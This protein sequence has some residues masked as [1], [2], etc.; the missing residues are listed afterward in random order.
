MYC[1]NCGEKLD[2]DA[3]FCKSCGKPVDADPITQPKNKTAEKPVNRCVHCG[4]KLD[5]DD[6]FCTSCGKPV[7][8][9]ANARPNAGTASRTKA[10]NQMNTT[11]ENVRKIIAALKN[12]DITAMKSAGEMRCTLDATQNAF[13]KLLKKGILTL[14]ALLLF[15][16]ARADVFP[17]GD[18]FNGLNI[19]YS[20]S[21]GSVNDVEDSKG[22]TESRRIFGTCSKGKVTISG[23]VYSDWG[24]VVTIR[25]S[26]DNGEKSDEKTYEMKST[27]KSQNFSIS[28]PVS[29]SNKAVSFRVSVGA[30]Y[31]NG[32]SRGLALYGT[33]DNTGYK[34]AN[35]KD[36]AD[37]GGN[38]S[39][40]TS[41]D[42]ESGEFGWFVPTAI[43]GAIAAGGIAL[44]NRKKKKNAN[45]SN[46]TEDSGAEKNDDE[47]DDEEDASYLMCIWKDFGDTLT[48]GGEPQRVYARIV[49]STPRNPGTTDS[50]LTSKINITG[51]GY[52][53]VS[54]QE[55][56]GEYMSALVEAPRTDDVPKGAVVNFC[57]SGGGAS[58]TN[59]MHF[60]IENC[61]P[62][63]NFPDWQFGNFMYIQ[64]TDNPSNKE[65]VHFFFDKTNVEPEQINFIGGDDFTIEV[66][67][68]EHQHEYYAII[69]N[70]RGPSLKTDEVFGTKKDIRIVIEALFPGQ[71]QVLGEFYIMLYPE[72]LCVL[73]KPKNGCI[74][75]ISY[76]QPS[77]Y[78]ADPRPYFQGADIY[79]SYAELNND[80]TANIKTE[81]RLQFGKLDA[82]DEMSCNVAAKYR[83]KLSLYNEHYHIEPEDSI[84]EGNQACVVYLPAY[85]AG[86]SMEGG[87]DLS[88]PLRLRGEK[89]DPMG[90]WKKEHHD[91]IARINRYFPDDM[92]Q[93]Y[94]NKVRDMYSDPETISAAELRFMSYRVIKE[95]Q[96]YWLKQR[97]EYEICADWDDY[98]LDVLDTA[99]SWGD[100]CFSIVIS[101]YFGSVTD[102]WLSPTKDIA[103]NLFG[104]I[105]VK[106]RYG[107]EFNY[108]SL[109]LYKNTTQ[110]G[111]NLILDGLDI[112]GAANPANMKKAAGIMVSYLVY[113]CVRKYFEKPPKERDWYD[114]IRDGFSDLTSTALKK[115]AGKYLEDIIKGENKVCKKL[116][117]WFNKYA[118]ETVKKLF[119]NGEEYF[120]QKILKNSI[121]GAARLKGSKWIQPSICLY[122]VVEK[123]ADL[124]EKF[125]YMDLI[126][127]Y[128]NDKLCGDGG[129]MD[130]RFSIEDENCLFF[131]LDISFCDGWLGY[132]MKP[133]E[134]TLHLK[135]PFK[136]FYSDACEL[137]NTLYEMLFGML[138]PA[139]A[140][141]YFSQD[142]I[143]DL[144]RIEYKN[145]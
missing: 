93:T 109:E 134:K 90:D 98:I 132:P 22:F 125:G 115:V 41:A 42:E 24:P 144:N 61:D 136:A 18:G 102:A 91:L 49:K 55:I 110:I 35:G 54:D 27:D 52:L 126:L 97:D 84:P 89:E 68:G 138:V 9:G 15:L 79:I 34:A 37:S 32:E 92:A 51:D 1:I 65:K 86:H 104:E 72:G 73:N 56:V 31:G 130:S 124:Y 4:E 12:N 17:G 26:I 71:I 133:E 94:I 50:V 85:V 23:T 123:D 48:L 119:S 101:Y 25:V 39:I 2:D 75:V 105:I 60:M 62:V 114:A 47:E 127:N 66:E 106:F 122:D 120:K 77:K 74:E 6:R 11:A 58:F 30:A 145:N 7:V 19:S 128:L 96:Y 143:V 3:R 43:A 28:I 45:K 40:N 135:I 137:T 59:R 83:Y 16:P 112:S 57:L 63:I 46:Q 80:Y 29:K 87:P 142:P 33:L 21:G 111:E 140:K 82:K 53:H 5:D 113:N 139:S 81:P 117:E 44:K 10:P 78:E 38:V 100:A 64:M 8:V 103:V 95:A 76:A 36:K 20:I 99:K 107:E 13:L 14:L 67:E 69:S 121:S 141:K 88:I 129:Y 108:K 118:N 131:D 70:Y 116:S